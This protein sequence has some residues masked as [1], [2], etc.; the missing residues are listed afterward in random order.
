MTICVA[1][2]VSVIEAYVNIVYRIFCRSWL[3]RKSTVSMNIF[4]KIGNVLAQS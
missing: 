2:V 1:L 3:G 4:V